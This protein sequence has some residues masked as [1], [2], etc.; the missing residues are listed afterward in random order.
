MT[1]YDVEITIQRAR[2]KF[3]GENPR[4]ISDNGPQYTSKEFEQ[5]LK[6]VGLRHIRIS[7]GY[8]QSNGKIERFYRSIEEECL[9]IKSI[10]DLEDARDVIGKYIKYYNTDRLH[11]SLHYLPPEDYLLGREKEKLQVR[12]RKMKEAAQKRKLYW[13]QNNAA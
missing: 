3:P 5:Y 10:L 9:R 11:S 7:V 2:E 4:I 12:E 13:S 6:E 8:P 1:E